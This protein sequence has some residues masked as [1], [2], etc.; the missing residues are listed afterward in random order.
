MTKRSGFTLVEVM[1]SMVML[2]IILT[3][4]ARAS[5]VIAV[6]GRSNDLS[7]KR[8]AVLQT[9]ANKFGAMSFAALQAFPTTNRSF[10]RGDFAYTRQLT[11]TSQSAINNRYSVKIVIIPQVDPSRPDSVIIERSLPPTG[12]PLCT[13]C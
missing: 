7:A 9:E 5:T 8:T 1:V 12:S 3:S 11:I 13:G 10:T 4:L 2:A 6:R